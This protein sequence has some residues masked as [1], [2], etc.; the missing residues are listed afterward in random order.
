M[1]VIDKVA[2]TSISQNVSLAIRQGRQLISELR[3]IEYEDKKKS[4]D[5]LVKHLRV[6]ERI[7]SAPFEGGTD[8]ISPAPYRIRE[9]LEAA[10]T[11]ARIEANNLGRV[12]YANKERIRNA[13]QLIEKLMQATDG[14]LVKREKEL[15]YLAAARLQKVEEQFRVVSENEADELALFTGDIAKRQNSMM[16]GVRSIM[17][18]A[19]DGS[20][21]YTSSNHEHWAEAMKWKQE[22]YAS[23]YAGVANMLDRALMIQ[24]KQRGMERRAGY[25][26]HVV[27]E[28]EKIFAQVE[29]G[30]F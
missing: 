7:L 11:Q 25:I 29:S 5:N 26:W 19:L 10:S 6:M 18:H 8:R 4:A 13:R 24:F 16:V 9:D 14:L 30:Q 28:I 2:Q 15:F 20:S 1:V 21:R 17:Q 23:A 27:E 12:L 3:S 22:K